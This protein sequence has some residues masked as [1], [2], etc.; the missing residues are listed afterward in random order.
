MKRARPHALH[1]LVVLALAAT[2]TIARADALEPPSACPPGQ[3]HGPGIMAG[4]LMGHDGGPPCRAASCADASTCGAGQVCRRDAHCLVVRSERELR[5]YDGRME[6]PDPDDPASYVDVMRNYD[7]GPCIDGACDEGARCMAIAVC[8]DE[9]IDA[10]PASVSG[11][12]SGP[13]WDAASPYDGAPLGP[14]GGASTVTDVEAEPAPIE[15]PAAPTSCLCRAGSASPV[16]AAGALAVAL[17]LVARI[18]SMRRRG[19]RELRGRAR[20]R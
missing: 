7:L 15:A 18:R 6:P 2:A 9:A 8:R 14:I 13:E 11:V 5:A 1:A 3:D 12:S 19:G 10:T 4:M 17:W 16:P 20:T